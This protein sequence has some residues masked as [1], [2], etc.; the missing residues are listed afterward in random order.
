MLTGLCVHICVVVNLFVTFV[1]KVNGVDC[2]TTCRKYYLH[3]VTAGEAR[4]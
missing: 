3:V 2:Q 1:F 4:G